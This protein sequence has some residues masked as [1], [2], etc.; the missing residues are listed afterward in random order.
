MDSILATRLNTLNEQNEKLRQAEGEYLLKEAKRKTMEGD[1]LLSIAKEGTAAEKAALVHTN[2]DYKS[3][4]GEL[5]GLETKFNFEKRRYEILTNA[6]F[7]EHS[8][9]KREMGL[10]QKEGI[11]V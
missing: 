1:L 7:A 11:N 2:E 6:F 10:I 9:F 4:M 3:F 5:A 8:T